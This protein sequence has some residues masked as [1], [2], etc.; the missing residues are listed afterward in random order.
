MQNDSEAIGARLKQARFAQGYASAREFSERLGVRYTTYYSWEKGTRPIPLSY[1]AIAS[2][3][4]GVSLDHIVLGKED[5]V[6]IPED[7]KSR[8]QAAAEAN[9]RSMNAEIIH[10]LQTTFQM[11]DYV[12]QENVHAD[13]GDSFP[14]ADLAD[15]VA[16]QTDLLEKQ[17]ILLREVLE[18]LSKT[19]TNNKATSFDDLL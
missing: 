6:Q 9:N 8:V 18:R 14:V 7:L 16:R 11:D 3:I 15:I 4:M 1:I 5:G 2:Q 12:P 13:E 17:D 19:S 10:R